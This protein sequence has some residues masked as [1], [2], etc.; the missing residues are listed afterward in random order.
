MKKATRRWLASTEVRDVCRLVPPSY[1]LA[2]AVQHPD[3]P[4]LLALVIELDSLLNV[5]S[6]DA[7][8]SSG[9]SEV[10]LTTRFHCVSPL[11]QPS[12]FS[13]A[14][15]IKTEMNCYILI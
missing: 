6:V 8:V 12:L 5:F 15:W 14:K 9:A 7:E 3:R 11:T 4:A 13:P 1:W 10:E 2:L